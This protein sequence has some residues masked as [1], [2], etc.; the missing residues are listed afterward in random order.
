MGLQNK[1][2][3]LCQKFGM[4]VLTSIWGVYVAVTVMVEAALVVFSRQYSCLSGEEMAQEQ[5]QPSGDPRK[6]ATVALQSINGNHQQI[7]LVSTSWGG[8]LF[9]LSTGCCGWYVQKF[10]SNVCFFFFFFLRQLSLKTSHSND[11]LQTYVSASMLEN[12]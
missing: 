12:V 11:V 5:T 1:F 2:Q 6:C 10:I 9:Y 8:F 7:Y 4:Q 3:L